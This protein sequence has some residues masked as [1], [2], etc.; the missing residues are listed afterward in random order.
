MLSHSD[1][2][3]VG[4]AYIFQIN[5]NKEAYIFFLI[6]RIKTRAHIFQ[7]SDLLLS[8]TPGPFKN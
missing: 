8:Y 1:S 2:E 7:I 3:Q 4:S 5:C 6:L